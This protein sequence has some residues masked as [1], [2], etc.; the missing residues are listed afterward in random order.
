MKIRNPFSFNKSGWKD[1]VT[2]KEKFWWGALLYLFITFI[3]SIVYEI[4]F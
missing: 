4:F 3:S 1:D 2:K